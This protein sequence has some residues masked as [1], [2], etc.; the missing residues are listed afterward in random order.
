[1]AGTRNHYEHCFSGLLLEHGLHALAVDES[2]RP[3]WGDRELKNFDFLVNG[4]ERVYAIDL[5]GRRETPWITRLDMFSMMAWQRLLG[6]TAQPAFVFAF[7]SEHGAET[8]RIGRLDATQRM[9]PS[10]VY[11][12]VMLEL[13]DAQRLARPRSERWGTLGFGW[14]GFARAAKPLELALGLGSLAS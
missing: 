6:D 13:A 1:M 8:G 14:T 9:T 4:A 2:R 11:R 3:L 12:F 7:Y 10:G 5:K